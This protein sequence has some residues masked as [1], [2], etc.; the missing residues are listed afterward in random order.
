M[1]CFLDGEC[2]HGEGFCGEE[3]EGKERPR[4]DEVG[5]MPQ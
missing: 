3:F 1:S 2:V 4:S 5:A